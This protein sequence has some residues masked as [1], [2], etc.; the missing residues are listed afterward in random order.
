MQPYPEDLCLSTLRPTK[1]Q[2][3][4]AGAR[5]S[6]WNGRKVSPVLD[7]DLPEFHR[8]RRE[9]ADRMSISGVQDKL[10]VHNEKG[11]LIPVTEGAEYLL[12]PIPS[13]PGLEL[14]SDVPANEHLT[15]QLAT[16]VFGIEVAPNGLVFFSDGTPA[17][18][19]RRFDRDAETGMK[20]PVED[21]CQLADRSEPSHGR[22]FRYDSSYEELGR[23]L[24]KFC[25][26]YRIESEK[27][28][29]II[30]FNY[31]VGNGDAH[32][33]NFS[34]VNTAEGDP[35]L[36]PAYDL[37]NTKLHIPTETSTALDLFDDFNTPEFEQRGFYSGADFRELARRYELVEQRA[38]KIIQGMNHL[39][40]AMDDLI[41]RSLLSK[42]AKEKYRLVVEDRARAIGQG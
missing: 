19:C 36:S 39:P 6:L 28:F 22:N 27:L 16:Q 40:P 1:G 29:R 24:S 3:Y 14:Q 18:V 41:A 35:L 5:N 9:A 17:Y 32:L 25:P 4:S 20:L 33:K 11:H 23:T 31:L 26:A 10:S 38:E 21:F 8:V 34:L 2:P 42:E 30:I 37:L 7:F 15:M 12:K 13:T